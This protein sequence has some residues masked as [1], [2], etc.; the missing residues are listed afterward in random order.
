VGWIDPAKISAATARD[1]V[2]RVLD[3]RTVEERRAQSSRALAVAGLSRPPKFIFGALKAVKAPPK[4]ERAAETRA[5]FRQYT[6]ER[7]ARRK[8]DTST[9]LHGAPL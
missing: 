1:V 8:A 9:N 3:D 2:E 7:R 6:R 4:R 5:Y